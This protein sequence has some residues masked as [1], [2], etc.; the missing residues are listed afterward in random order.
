MKKILLILFILMILLFIIPQNNNINNEK[1]NN[2][3]CRFPIS[4]ITPMNLTM[5]INGNINLNNYFIEVMI[6][7]QQINYYN[8]SYN[9]ANQVSVG[10][11]VNVGSFSSYTFSFGLF[12][13]YET[14]HQMGFIPYN[15]YFY[16]VY[17]ADYNSTNN[18]AINGNGQSN[19]VS[20]IPNYSFQFQN[21]YGSFRYINGTSYT[22]TT[23]INTI[24][25]ASLYYQNFYA[26]NNFNLTI[27]GNGY[28]YSFNNVK[29][30]N[31]SLPNGL[32]TYTVKSN[33]LSYSSN[34]YVNDNHNNINVNLVSNVYDSIFIPFIGSIIA[35]FISIIA[36]LYF[37]RNSNQFAL[38]VIDATIFT[39][40]YYILNLPFFN[41]ALISFI[42]VVFMATISYKI[43]LSDY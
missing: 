29:N 9:T 8:Y 34:F 38:V 4:N 26:S 18:P 10:S 23:T 41:L 39:L 30:V 15:T 16:Y 13:L 6:Y 20:A 33:N 1:V 32:Y 2:D 28:N 19:D 24:S 37:D 12:N 7:S 31:V 5:T 40:I 25:Q 3:L 43:F 42:V 27:I 36:I 22:S 14:N 35:L 11:L 17:V 21:Q